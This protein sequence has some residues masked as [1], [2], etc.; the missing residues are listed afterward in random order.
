MIS[1]CL[2]SA[3][4]PPI[5]HFPRCLLEMEERLQSKKS[6]APYLVQGVVQIGITDAGVKRALFEMIRNVLILTTLLIGAGILGR[7]FPDV[8]HYHP[9]AKAGRSRPP[10]R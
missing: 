7:A 4:R 6:A 1:P 2:S 3:N 9:V 5:R 10:I 8:A